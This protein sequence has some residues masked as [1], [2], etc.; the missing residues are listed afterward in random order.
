MS[1]K[2][3]ALIS[4]MLTI[5]LLVVL[6]ILS[7]FVQMLALNGASQGQG[8]TAMGISLACQGAG[9]I[10]LGVFAGWF[11]RLAITKF[12]WSR[13]IAVAAA[14]FLATLFGGG[15]SFLSVLLSIPLAGIQ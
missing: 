3:P 13:I 2:T 8:M 7:V 14:V 6:G 12:N 5:M 4:T 10:L 9:T 11:T 15:I 1:N